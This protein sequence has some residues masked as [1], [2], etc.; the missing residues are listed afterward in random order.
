MLIWENIRYFARCHIHFDTVFSS[1]HGV[2]VSDDVILW[3]DTHV[4]GGFQY[5]SYKVLEFVGLNKATAVYVE[6]L[7]DLD[8]K[9]VI[10][11]S[12]CDIAL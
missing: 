7:P 12:P 2:S 5:F 11:T 3:Y 10:V 4:I 8:I 1:Y 6:P 9:E